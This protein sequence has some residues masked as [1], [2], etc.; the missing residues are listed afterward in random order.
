MSWVPIL[1]P[2]IKVG[3]QEKFSSLFSASDQES[4]WPFLSRIRFRNA[5]QRNPGA[6]NA[7]PRVTISDASSPN[8]E[9]AIRATQSPIQI[10]LQKIAQRSIVRSSSY[11]NRSIQRGSIR[12][13][14]R[15]NLA[16]QPVDQS[17][18]AQTSFK[19]LLGANLGQK[20][21]K[22][23]GSADRPSL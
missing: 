19:A 17:Y 20:A 5:A 9:E 11:S 4:I 13:P 6:D 10:E 12:F 14:R 15:A 8:P 22:K 23:L 21:S 3:P 18:P 16:G 2:G 7:V 1:R